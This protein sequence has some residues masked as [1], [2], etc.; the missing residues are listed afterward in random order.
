[1]AENNNSK[2][3]DSSDNSEFGLDEEQNKLF[4]AD[5]SLLDEERSLNFGDSGEASDI[6]AL[7]AENADLKNKYLRALADFENFKKRTVKDRSDLL[8]Y[9]GEK[10]LLDML[11]IV[12][13]LEYALQYADNNSGVE[14]DPVKLKEGLVL[15]HKRFLETLSKWEVRPQS[16]LGSEFDPAKCSAISRVPA[17]GVQAGIVLNELKKAYFYKDK[18]LRVGEVVVAGES[19]EGAGT[20]RQ[21]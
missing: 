5:F 11:E 2:D 6:S 9:Q 18:L 16:A 19:P 4:D 1:M 17:P 14:S 15:I 13:N 21:A 7:K 20:D 8:K 12:D 3:N 10:I